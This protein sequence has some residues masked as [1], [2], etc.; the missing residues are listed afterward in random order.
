MALTL[1]YC[2]DLHLEFELNRKG[3]AKYPLIVKGDILLLAG[4][5][6]PFALLDE[7]EDFFDFAARNYTATYWIPGN[8]EYYG[9][10]IEHRSG[11]VYEEVRDNV[12]LVNNKT[13]RLDNTDIICSTLWSHIDQAHEYEITRSMSD[14]HVIKQGD[15]KLNIPRQNELHRECRQYVENA[16]ANSD[17]LHKVVM[18]HHIPTLMNYPAKYRESILNQ[19]FA[20]EM[21]DL[22]HSS[23]TDYWIF[24]HH[25]CNIPDFTIAR[26]TLTTNQLGY[27]K[28]GEHKNFNKSKT[29][30]LA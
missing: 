26:T 1:Q 18:T 16:I 25:H 6:V 12:F 29:I 10:D 8:H 17:A 23:G 9:S 3:V 7:H 11:E 20:V 2:S 5:I 28:H 24:G 15:G 22:I 30:T 4:D 27:V 13:I 21:H 14:Y 19:A